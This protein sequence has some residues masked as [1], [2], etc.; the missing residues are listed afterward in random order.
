MI[1]TISLT[2]SLIQRLS[3]GLSFVAAYGFAHSLGMSPDNGV[4]LTTPLDNHH[5]RNLYGTFADGGEFA[6]SASYTIPGFKSP[7]QILQGWSLNTILSLKSRLPWGVNDGTTDFSGTGEV[8]NSTLIGEQ[9]DFFGNASDFKTT[10]A[11]INT[12]G[13]AGGIPYFPGTS[14]AT[15]L[16]KS[17]AMGPLAVASLTNLGCYA[18]GSS[19]MVPPAYGSYGTLGPGVFRG[20]PYYNVSLSV[21]KN[22]K[23]QE[24]LTAQFRVEFFNILNHP[25]I[26][27]VWGG[28]GGGG[29]TTFTDLTA[30]NPFGFR[31]QTPDVTSSNT[32]LGSGGPRVIQMGLKLI[33]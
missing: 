29:D 27:S 8:N 10:K 28:P 1:S 5:P 32:V 31:N 22:W 23:F 26:S 24:R 21:T 19:V 12:N 3:H 14:N 13:G 17:Q 16:A 20:M 9:W 30:N 7:G 25:N 15:C 33:F 6:A 4:L 11:L 18:S 2:T